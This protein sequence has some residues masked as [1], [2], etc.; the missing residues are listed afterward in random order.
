M[1]K[2]T[3][4]EK[5]LETLWRN[6]IID[7]RQLQEVLD[8][9]KKEGG[10][11]GKILVQKGLIDQRSLLALLSQ[12]LNIPP[13]DLSKY[14]IAPDIVRLI[15]KKLCE[16]FDLIP[17]SKIGNT[18]TIAMADP[19]DILALDDIKAILPYNI[20]TV[21]ATK[22]GI[23]EALARVYGIGVEEELKEAAI[24]TSKELKESCEEEI[25]IEKLT[26]ESQKPS[27]IKLVSLIIQEGLHRRA[28]DIHIEPE[29]D[30]LRVRYRIDGVL[31]EAF[32]LPKENQNAII[33]RLKIMSK[34]DITENILPQDGRFKI[35]IE[36]KEIDFRVSAL[37]L[38][39]G[40]KIVLR[41]L[42]RSNIK[43]GLN[44]LGFL[45]GPLQAFK[46]ALERAFGMILL[47][48]PTGSGKS[49]TL[50]SIINNLNTPDRNIVTIEDPVEYQLD[51][52]TQIQVNP[53]IGLTFANG[54]RAVLRQNPDVVM[55]GEIRDFETADIAIKASLTGQLVL[56]TLHTNDA[57]GAITRLIDMGVEPFLVASSVI[58]AA[59]QRLCRKIC[60][61][62]KEDVNIPSKVL[63]KLTDK[64]DV[65]MK[66][67]P[68][69][70]GKGCVRCNQT[71]YLGRVGVLETLLIDDRIK[72]MIVERRSS[73]E[74]ETYAVSQGMMTL[75][76]SAL[77]LFASGIT[78][79]EEVIRV[80][81]EE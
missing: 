43:V 9:H 34:L 54:L 3:L 17:I 13:I 74:I 41:A 33:A 75:R 5:L 1:D 61:Y 39:F 55:I 59:A 76:E 52:I 45:T 50:Y 53:D 73:D 4:P 46:K 48:G 29:E 49:T 16:Q 78:T 42:D 11:I 20:D 77:E 15:P 6:N 80:T 26:A 57:A 23:G 60:P 79:L 31:H 40:N 67:K 18:I 37:P 65:F 7:K 22:Q 66:R 2:K 71:G 32:Q 24:E 35:R 58:L 81:V 56:S 62:C 38:S 51:G 44:G 14:N 8:T 64:V 70:R 36:G 68:F 47:T 12:L 27:I 19:T 69:Y 63:A 21:I 72:D 30:K 10:S 25:D 28:S